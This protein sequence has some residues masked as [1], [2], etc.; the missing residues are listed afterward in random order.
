MKKLNIFFFV[1][2]ASFISLNIVEADEG[3]VYSP[4]ECF[5]ITYG[6]HN[7]H[8]HQAIQNGNEYIAVGDP[9]YTYP[10]TETNE[11]TL[12]SITVNNNN[13]TITDKMEFKT[14][15]ATATIVATPNYPNAKVEYENSKKLEIGNNKINIVVT[16]ASGL[17]KT[18]ELNIIRQKVLST[19]NNIKNITIDNKKYTFKDNQITN[20]FITSGH[21]SLDI[22]VTKEDSTSKIKIEGNEN[23]KA[24]DNTITIICQAENGEI[25]KYYIKFHKSM[26]LTDIIGTIIGVLILFLP[27]IIIILII[28]HKNKKKYINN[29]HYYKKIK[30]YK[31]KF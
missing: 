27:V 28:A 11:P 2:F 15:D 4:R 18:Y 29:S 21:K 16:S 14:Y 8:W 26:F 17:T 25:Q 3:V 9:I 24:G 19:N 23:L 6:T 5:G 10:C 22:K 31:I 13:I 20:L 12:K 7:G 30:N 1:L